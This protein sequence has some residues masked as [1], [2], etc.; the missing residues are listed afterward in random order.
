[1]AYNFVDLRNDLDDFETAASAVQA[2]FATLATNRDLVAGQLHTTGVKDLYG[3][4]YEIFENAKRSLEATQTELV[5][6]QTWMA[7][8]CGFQLPSS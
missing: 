7:R 1:M 5:N 6:R 8:S 4:A 2:M 3:P